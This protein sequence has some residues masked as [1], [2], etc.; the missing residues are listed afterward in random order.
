VA[1][2]ALALTGCTAT[3]GQPESAESPAPSVQVESTHYIDCQTPYVVR[4]GEGWE[5]IMQAYHVMGGYDQDKRLLIDPGQNLLVVS[6]VQE[7]AG[8]IRYVEQATIGEAVE[9]TLQPGWEIYITRKPETG[10]AQVDNL[11]TLEELHQAPKTYEVIAG[12]WLM[13]ILEKYIIESQQN[14]SNWNRADLTQVEIKRNGTVVF[15]GTAK[16]A[17]ATDQQLQTGDSVTVGPVS[18]Q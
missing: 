2:L 14:P 18:R 12:D 15:S 10:I 1:A 17:V 3:I 6:V 5:N 4:E 8:G 16:E 11:P 13:K 9:G 7:G